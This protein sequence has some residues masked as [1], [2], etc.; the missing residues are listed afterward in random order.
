MSRT[1]DRNRISHEGHL[2]G[3]FFG[4]IVAAALLGFQMP[5]TELKW[6]LYLGL[7]PAGAYVIL[8]GLGWIKN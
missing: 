2:G 3:L 5:I 8:H 6:L 7:L 1:Q 4:G